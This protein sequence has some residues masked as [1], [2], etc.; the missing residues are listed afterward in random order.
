[1]GGERI[2]VEIMGGLG[3]WRVLLLGRRLNLALRPYDFLNL[4]RSRCSSHEFGLFAILLFL[5]GWLALKRGSLAG[6]LENG[7]CLFY[8]LFISFG[9]GSEGEGRAILRKFQI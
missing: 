9:G 6:R 1:M 8:G 2:C 3:S 5:I 4:H 7:V